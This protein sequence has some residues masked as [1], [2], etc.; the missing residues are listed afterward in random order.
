MSLLVVRIKKNSHSFCKQCI[1][2]Y[3][4]GNNK[5]PI[6]KSYFEYIIKKEINNIL[7]KLSFHWNFKKE[8][9]NDIIPYYDYLRHINSCKH[10]NIA[11][12]CLVKK[13]NY[14]NK[15]FEKCGYLGN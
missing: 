10:N 6:Y 7:F 8:G 12:E 5:C 13:Y 3:L 9:C 14:S 4:N 15:E 2:I 1:D 11:F